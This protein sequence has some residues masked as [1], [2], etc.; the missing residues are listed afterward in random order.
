MLLL[1]FVA[2]FSN[3]HVLQANGR[4]SNYQTQDTLS[5]SVSFG[6]LPSKPFMGNL[7]VSVLVKDIQSQK[8]ILN[9]NVYISFKSPVNT[10]WSE[11]KKLYS[12]FKQYSSEMDYTV[13][14]SGKWLWKIFVNKPNSEENTIFEIHIGERSYNLLIP[15]TFFVFLIVTV[16]VLAILI[17]K[18]S[19]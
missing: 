6:T 16:I 18:H 9:P 10:D 11:P 4:V 19:T 3:Q 12:P 1:G 17:K 8:L 7:H 2:N 13:N 14:T 15:I 5:Y